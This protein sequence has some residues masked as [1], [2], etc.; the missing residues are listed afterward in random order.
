MPLPFEENGILDL[1]N[2]FPPM[3]SAMTASAIP[4][5]A[6]F[7]HIYS[8]QAHERYFPPILSAMTVSATFL[9]TLA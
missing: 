7:A 1:E 2:Y 4:L 6:R 9:G 3:R 5:D 8:G